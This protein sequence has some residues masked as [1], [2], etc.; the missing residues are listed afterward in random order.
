MLRSID[1]SLIHQ[2]AV[3]IGRSSKNGMKRTADRLAYSNVDK[4]INQII[5]SLKPQAWSNSDEII[6][7]C[8]ARRLW[9]DWLTVEL[10]N[11]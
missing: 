5:K 10:K 9:L 6:I 3:Q 2:K 4:A 7:E 8:C 1:K 11:I